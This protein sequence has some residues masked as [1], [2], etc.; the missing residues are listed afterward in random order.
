LRIC[1]NC[2][3]PCQPLL[4]AFPGWIRSP[5]PIGA[6]HLH[7]GTMPSLFHSFSVQQ[8][9]HPPCLAAVLAV[10]RATPYFGTNAGLLIVQISL[11]V[12]S[13]EGFITCASVIQSS[14]SLLTDPPQHSHH[15]QSRVAIHPVEYDPFIKS[16]LASRD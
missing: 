5:P 15:P 3:A 8:M 7:N 10:I 14:M 16:Q 1:A 12:V 9:Q 6:L 11:Y 13:G 2:C 4:R